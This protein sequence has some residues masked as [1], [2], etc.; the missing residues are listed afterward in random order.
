MSALRSI[1]ELIM[2]DCINKAG[3]NLTAA[4]H[5]GRDAYHAGASEPPRAQHWTVAG[6]FRRGY[7]MA[8]KSDRHQRTLAAKREAKGLAGGT[9]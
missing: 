6:E 3:E 1:G 9:R 7:I 2:S 4:Y 5:Q 8:R